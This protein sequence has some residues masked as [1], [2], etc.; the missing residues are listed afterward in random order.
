MTPQETTV[1]VCRY[2][3]PECLI[4]YGLCHCGCGN[5]STISNNTD[6]RKNSIKG[7]PNKFIPYHNKLQPR[8]DVSGAKPFKI[9]GVYCRLIPLTRGQWTIVWE[10]RF[11]WL[12]Q[13]YWFSFWNKHT[14]S[15][16]AARGVKDKNGRRRIRFMAQDILS[17][18][19]GS[20]LN[21]DHKNGVTLDNRDANLRDV[22]ECQNAQNH[23]IISTNT[24]GRTGVCMPRDKNYWIASLTCRGKFYRKGG[25]RTFE[26]AVAHREMLEEKYHG[27]YSR[28]REIV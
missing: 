2:C 10:T 20:D 16:Y 4:E 1:P 11:E 7:L 13:W 14:K 21:G 15:F 12:T 26:G 8:F 23:K 6:N 22:T 3:G 9:D 27:E 17:L 5:R 18:E 25:F 24:S 19:M 28:N